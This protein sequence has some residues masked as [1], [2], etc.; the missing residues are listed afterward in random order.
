MEKTIW[1]IVKLYCRHR[2]ILVLCR[3]L[4]QTNRWTSLTT[5][6]S[7]YH[8]DLFVFTPKTFFL[9]LFQPILPAEGNDAAYRQSKSI[10]INGDHIYAFMCGVNEKLQ[11]SSSKYKV[12]FEILEKNTN[13]LKLSVISS[14]SLLVFII[15][16]CIFRTLLSLL[17]QFSQSINGLE[18]YTIKFHQFDPIVRRTELKNKSTKWGIQ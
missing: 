10:C 7:V 8:I 18:W 13:Y 17:N 9:D 2:C 3:V 6:C 5:K 15:Q 4:Q 16:S 11:I 14:W 12:V 1:A